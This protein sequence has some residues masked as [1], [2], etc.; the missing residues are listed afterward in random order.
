MSLIVR[1]WESIFFRLHVPCCFGNYRP[2]SA[3][4]GGCASAQPA[5]HVQGEGHDEAGYLG[6]LWTRQLTFRC[7]PCFGV[8]LIGSLDTLMEGVASVRLVDLDRCFGVCDP[9]SVG[10]LEAS[11][12]GQGDRCRQRHEGKGAR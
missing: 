2:V 10:L 6:A 9:A 4:C 5:A 11:G 3:G 12:V 8:G 1:R 7:G